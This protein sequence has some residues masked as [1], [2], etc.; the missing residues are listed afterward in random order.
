MNL[1]D[2]LEVGGAAPLRGHVRVPGDKSISHR[3]LLFGALA[4]GR[5]AITHLASGADVHATRLALEHLGVHIR[6]KGGT[7]IVDADGIDAWTEPDRVIDCENSGTMMRTLLGALAGR[8]FLAVLT[9]DASLRQRPM[10]RVVDPLRAMGAHIDGRNDGDL[11]PLAV[12]GGR[13]HGMRHELAVASAQVKTALL[14]AGIQADG[15]TEVVSPGPT[16]DHTERML[17]ALGVAV[18]CDGNVVAIERSALEPLEL[19][20]P[21]DPSSAAFFAVAAAITPGSDIV[22]DDMSC[23]PTRTGFVEVLRRMGA[24]IELMPRGEACGEPYGELR[25]RSS[26]LSATTIA[27]EEIGNVIDEIP[28]LAIAAAFADGVT[29]VRDAA[30][31]AV[32]ESN[33]IGTIH[34]ELT[35]LGAQVETRPDGL[36]IRGGSP[37]RAG[38]LKSHGDH[39]IAMAAAVAAHALDEHSI[40]RGWRAV[41]SSYPEFAAD[42]EHLTSA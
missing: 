12:R 30:E 13:L 24:D 41:A 40:V 26:A 28:A 17:S 1:A 18:Q 34:Q 27:G 22:I 25:V 38:R 8:P 5:S 32:K 21:G 39:R 23:N 16:R 7:V 31:L 19:D 9:G 11:A 20:V 14:L 37:L 4:H 3:A 10:R 35:Q 2:E 15:R 29:E 42:L 36:V 33:R 6:T